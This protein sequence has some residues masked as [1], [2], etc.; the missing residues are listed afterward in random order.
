MSDFQKMMEFRN[1][2]WSMVYQCQA[3]KID[4]DAIFGASENLEACLHMTESICE[5]MEHALTCQEAKFLL[6]LID[7]NSREYNIDL[8]PERPAI[9]KLRRI[10]ER[11]ED[12]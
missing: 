10:A 8:G 5:Q 2:S 6:T 11:I 4:K 9:R 7:V 12:R 1:A 3:D